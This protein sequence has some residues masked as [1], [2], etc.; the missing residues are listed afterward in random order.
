MRSELEHEAQNEAEMYDMV[1]W[2]ETNEKEKTKAIADA[3][4]L[5]KELTAEIGARAAKLGE[6]ETNIAILKEQISADTA[7]LKE[8]TSIREADAAKFYESNKDLVQSITN[9]K[10]AI[11][12][13]GKHNAPKTMFLQLDA[14]LAA[15]LRAVMKDLAEKQEMM[16][17]DQSERPRKNAGAAFLSMGTESSLGDF[18]GNQDSAMPLEFAQ[19]VLARA[20]SKAPAFRQS[21]TAPSG[22]SYAPQSNQIF[23][24]LTTMKEEFEANLGTEQ[25]D[26]KKAAVDFEAMAA[27]KTAQIAVGK[28]K[29]DN[30]EGANAD[31]IKALS[32]AKENLEMTREQ[33][34]KD[35]EFL[36]NLQTTCMGLDKQ[37]GIRSKTRSEET[38]AVSEAIKIITSDDSMDLLRHSVTLIQ[39]DSQATMKVR[40]SRAISALRAAAKSPAFEADDLLA[41]WSGRQGS[42]DKLGAAGGPKMR[43]STLAVS[44]SLDSFTKIKEAMDKMVADLKSEQAEEVKFKTYCGKEL[45][46]NEKSTYEKTENKE[47][48]EALIAKLTK[49]GKKLSEEIASANA[50]IADT[51][52]AIKKAS[53][54]RE[55]ENAEFQAVVGDQRATQAILNKALSRLQEF[56]KTQ[57]GGALL[58]KAAQTPP[59]QFGKMKSNAGASPVI[60]MIQ[61]II[62]DSKALEAEAVAGETEAQASYESFVKDSNAVIKSLSDSVASKTSAR[63]TATSDNEQ[64][65]SDLG[66]TNGELESLA[67]TEE[68]LHGECD[69][70][71]KNFAA[72]QQARLDEMEAIGQAK[73]IL[74]GAQ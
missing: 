35:I 56:Y 44:V 7:S 23:G 4:A 11:D 2:C 47:D 53:Q 42:Q 50:Q 3:E 68:D 58:Q 9:A 51:E 19:K 73:G 66:S 28:E 12:V 49:L 15:S 63:A 22:G 34:S 32:D 41:A 16:R 38:A 5:D 21:A 39:V 24:I 40:R 14:S 43:L 55:G 46:A 30:L 37:W 31:N 17:A 54:A 25:T 18:L 60:G 20:A 67:L 6:A 36:Q 29:L 8:A 33:R 1:C 70:T 48:L 57:K 26:E 62:E 61:Q 69:W 13:L 65:K 52:V 72:R 64:A 74:S 59:V 45:D 10:N 27:A 71:I